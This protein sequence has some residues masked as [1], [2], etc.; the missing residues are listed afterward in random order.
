MPLEII[1][2]QFALTGFLGKDLD[3][4]CMLVQS[5]PQKDCGESTMTFDQPSSSQ[6][7]KVKWWSS[8]LFR[9][10]LVF[11]LKCGCLYFMYHFRVQTF[12]FFGSGSYQFF[13]DLNSL[14]PKYLNL[15]SYLK[16]FCLDLSHLFKSGSIHVYN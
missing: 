14:G 2:K 3:R 9:Q 16:F 11:V 13:S 15:I 8:C 7:N 1:F 12:F 5:N 6:T 10:A 4:L